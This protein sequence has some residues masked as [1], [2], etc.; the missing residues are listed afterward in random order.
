MEWQIKATNNKN[1]RVKSLIIQC[2]GISKKLKLK[3]VLRSFIFPHEKVNQ[4]RVRCIRADMG[5]VTQLREPQTKDSSS[6]IYF[7]IRGKE[8]GAG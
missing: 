2:D 8:R 5:I 3:K 1:K 4:L 7:G 6:F